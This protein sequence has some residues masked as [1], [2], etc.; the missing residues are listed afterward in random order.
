[1]GQETYPSPEKLR[2]AAYLNLFIEKGIT[3]LLIFT[4]LAFGTVQEWSVS[5]METIVFLVFG[6]WLFKTGL[7][8]KYSIS[9]NIQLSLLTLLILVAVAQIIPLP[10]PLL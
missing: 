8:V 6:V 4:P 9:W 1:M 5:V 7:E 3:F 10:E 2:Y